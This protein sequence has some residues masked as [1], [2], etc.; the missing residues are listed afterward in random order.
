[1][2]ALRSSHGAWARCFTNN[3]HRGC[4]V[5]ALVGITPQS[6]EC[7]EQWGVRCMPTS[8]RWPRTRRWSGDV[9]SPTSC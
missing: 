2:I 3:T 9:C 5:A 7:S 1:M 6:R 4:Q 8:A